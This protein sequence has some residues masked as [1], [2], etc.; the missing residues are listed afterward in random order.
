MMCSTWC[1]SRS[2]LETRLPLR[3][4]F[5]PSS[6]AELFLRR[7]LLSA[8]DHPVHHGIYWFSGKASL[9]LTPHGSHW[10]SSRSLIRI[11]SLRTSCFLTGREVLWT[12]SSV[13]SSSVVTRRRLLLV[14]RTISVLFNVISDYSGVLVGLL[15]PALY[16]GGAGA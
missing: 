10:S 2:S 5:H 12:D 15:G 16:K 14:A 6:M 3:C 8:Q 13:T 4:L 11:S 1:S 7:Q 9:M